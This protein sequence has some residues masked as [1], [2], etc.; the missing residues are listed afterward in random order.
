MSNND[1]IPIVEVPLDEAGDNLDNIP[2]SPLA[3]SAS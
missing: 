3:A 2:V 1:D